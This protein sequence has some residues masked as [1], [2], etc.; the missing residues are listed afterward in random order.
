MKKQS[1]QK[2]LIEKIIKQSPGFKSNH[3]LFE[4]MMEESVKRLESFFKDTNDI[5]S[6]EVY[7]KKI[8]SS[9]IIDVI[10]NGETLREEKKKKIKE[11]FDFNE[12]S[13]KYDLNENGEILYN[14]ELTV[15]E[16]PPEIDISEEKI[17]TLKKTIKKMDEENPEKEIKRIFEL[18]FLKAADYK[19]IAKNLKLQE[20]DVLKTLLEIFKQ[21]DL[22]LEYQ[23]N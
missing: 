6:S 13:I 12:T 22:S 3:D 19:K 23:K 17:N 20:K 2:E 10:K 15:P 11:L 16:K 21:I 18:R 1:K 8:I 5:S 7:V 9:V 14:L 4:E